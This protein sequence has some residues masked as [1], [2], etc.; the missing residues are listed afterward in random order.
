MEGS[1]SLQFTALRAQVS[2]VR[3]GALATGATLSDNAET[4]ATRGQPPGQRGQPG[5][6][7]L[8]A[9]LVRARVD[10]LLVQSLRTYGST[11]RVNGAPSSD[12]TNS[13]RVFDDVQAFVREIFAQT[14]LDVELP[15]TD[16][17]AQ[18]VADGG[19]WSIDATA[20]RIIDFVRGFFDI[21]PS[22]AETLRAA[23]DEG[24]R[25]A[26]AAWGGQLPEI[27][28]R[29]IERVRQA[30]DELI[31]SF[32]GADNVGRPSAPDP[33]RLSVADETTASAQ[34]SVSVVRVRV[35]VSA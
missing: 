25:Q 13:S 24:F 3:N 6:P 15:A 2:H 23:V 20:G 26:E 16:E 17:A 9:T 18:Q 5:Q 14:G 1:L 4:A 7:V 10:V 29:T 12:L 32:D 11:G 19:H 30:L 22:L 34:I 27:S 33:G 35:E 8:S 21:D 31:G 28:H